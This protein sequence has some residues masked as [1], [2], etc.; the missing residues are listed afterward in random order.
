MLEV[1]AAA[2]ETERKAGREE[3]LSS[4]LETYYDQ[5]YRRG[6]EAAAQVCDEHRNEW[7]HDKECGPYLAERIREKAKEGK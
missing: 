5:G 1:I 4:P 7:P 3:R 6:L 2:L